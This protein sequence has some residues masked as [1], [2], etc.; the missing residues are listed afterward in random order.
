MKVSLTGAQAKA[1]DQHTIT[2]IGIP[3]EVLM[4]RAALACADKACELTGPGVCWIACGSGNNGAD[5]IAV[6]RILTQRG[7]SVTLILAGNEEHA[8]DEYRLQKQIA[9]NLGIPMVSLPQLPGSEPELIVDALFGVGLSRDVG[10]PYKGLIEVLSGKA[11][12]KKLAVDLPSGINADTGAVCGCA[13]AADAT[14]TFGHLKNGLLLYPGRSYAGSVTV[15]DIG[16]PE[17][18]FMAVGADARVLER[19]DLDNLPARPADANKGTFGKILIIAGCEGMS[20]AAYLS[21]LGAYR[22]GAGLVKILTAESNRVILQS[23]LP[24]A[25]V[26]AYDPVQFDD[27]TE[28]DSFI[29]NECDWADT[30]VMGP[31]LGRAPYVNVLMELVLEHAYVPMVLDADALNAIARNPYLTRYLTENMIITPH[32]GEMS[33]LTG[34]EVSRIK[35]APLS[36]ARQYSART[37]A[38][39]VLKDAA[40]VIAD[41]D[42]RAFINTSGCSAMSKG[43]SGDVLSGVI[44]ALLSQGM[45]CMDAAAYGVYLHGLAGEEAGREKGERGVLSRDIA[46][47]V[48]RFMQDEIKFTGGHKSYE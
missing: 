47:C 11:G 36:S 15:A 48:P 43:G 45:E 14:V 21:A 23:L 5:G 38:V 44:G 40:T 42:G 18:S 30:I 2:Q 6:G 9:H 29:Q 26:S 41:K 24:E 27:V 19:T 3:S 7:F 46:D 4:E 34:L 39:C 37:L 13:L 16:L 8:T 1:I 33:R 31:G 32:V 20:G 10:E 35:A 28:T 12:A 22:A 25:I 17:E